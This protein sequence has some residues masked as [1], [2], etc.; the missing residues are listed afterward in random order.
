MRPGVRETIEAVA[1]DGDEFTAVHHFGG[2]RVEIIA[3]PFAWA[4][5][6]VAVRDCVGPAAAHLAV[7]AQARA[8][9]ISRIK[10]ISHNDVMVTQPPA[11]PP[12]PDEPHAACGAGQ[13]GAGRAGGRLLVSAAVSSAR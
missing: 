13:R 3:Y 11:G 5:T 7:S 8:A 2:S 4:G 12:Y 6:G 9:F 10:H 1:E